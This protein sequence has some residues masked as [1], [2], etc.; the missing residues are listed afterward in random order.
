MIQAFETDRFTVVSA[1]E[2]DRAQL[3]QALSQFHT[4]SWTGPRLVGT[5]LAR[6]DEMLLDIDLSL[7][8]MGPGTRPD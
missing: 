2:I 5:R 7:Q 3:P 4:L 6:S 1:A 8:G